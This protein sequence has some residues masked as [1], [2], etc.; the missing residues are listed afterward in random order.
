MAKQIKIKN[1]K[2][3]IKKPKKE[4]TKKT[5]R[6][7]PTLCHYSPP[8]GV[9]SKFLCFFFWGGV[10]FFSFLVSCFLVRCCCF[11]KGWQNN[12]KVKDLD[13][14]LCQF[15]HFRGCKLAF[16]WFYCLLWACGSIRKQCKKKTMA[17]CRYHWR[18]LGGLG[19]Q[20]RQFC[21]FMYFSQPVLNTCKNI[22]SQWMCRTD[23]DIDIVGSNPW[24]NT[25]SHT[26]KNPVKRS[27]ASL[28]SECSLQQVH[29]F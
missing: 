8:W 9:Q 1:K 2:Q 6:Q 13:L 28:W 29:F 7:D 4:T 5:K 27:D 19:T 23:F 17:K 11:L 24:V 10:L 12:T 20:I 18:K 25:C 15:S 14:T 3:K 22:G 21:L 26:L 16:G